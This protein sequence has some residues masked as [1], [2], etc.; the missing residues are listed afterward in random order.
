MELRL[1][2]LDAYGAVLNGLFFR[3]LLIPGK[4]AKLC[5]IEEVLGAY[6][7]PN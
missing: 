4:I 5:K 1:L 7:V 2:S 3:V 6:S